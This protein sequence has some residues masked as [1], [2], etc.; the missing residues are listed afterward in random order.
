M[1]LCDAQ[2]SSVIGRR[3]RGSWSS[4]TLPAKQ[5]CNA[6]T[7]LQTLLRLT[8]TLYSQAIQG[9][10]QKTSQIYLPLGCSRFTG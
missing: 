7:C 9:E 8:F 2:V 4:N 5:L 10:M 6:N 3:H 1:L